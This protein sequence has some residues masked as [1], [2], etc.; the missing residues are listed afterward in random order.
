MT[1]SPRVST[2]K[3]SAAS[4]AERAA[5]SAATSPGFD[6]VLGNDR[7]KKILR[8][9]LEKGRVPNSLIFSGPE[10]VGKRRLAVILAQAL[11]CERGE[12]EPCGAC[13]TCRKIKEG[14][15]P[16]VIKIKPG[17]VSKLSISIDE[18]QEV[19][20]AAYVKPRYGRL[21]RVFIVFEADKMTPDAANCMLKV[22][23]EP[24][25]DS[26]FILVT[27]MPHLIPPTIKSR[28][29]TLDFVPIR[30]EEIKRALAD[31]GWPEEQAGAIALYVEGNLEEALTLDW[32]KNR[33]EDWE[34]IQAVR[35][36]AWDLFTALQGQG[37][38]TSFLRNYAYSKRDEARNRLTKVLRLAATFCRDANLLQAGGDR[39]LLLN[40]DYAEALIDLKTRWGFEEYAKCLSII[41]QA[42]A[43]LK[44]LN[45]GLLIMS[46][47]S[48]IGEPSHG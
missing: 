31:L 5:G 19:R 23:E 22:L 15:L 38:S 2:G 17:R 41:E 24:P 33:E 32:E 12:V 48:L 14:K 21:R 8:L 29:Q 4:G 45:L 20:Q 39:S 36:E 3:R 18:M 30:R 34:T 35:R 25:S 7:I 27:S 11:N 13:E 16:E 37:D 42:I 1:R 6:E 28:C 10:G 40:P 43:G 44:N 46:L 26:Y 9:A 47:Y